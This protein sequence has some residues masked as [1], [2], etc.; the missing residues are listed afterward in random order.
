MPAKM[1][2]ADHNDDFL[3]AVKYPSNCEMNEKCFVLVSR[4]HICKFDPHN[5]SYHYT[6]ATATRLTAFLELMSWFSS[7]GER[8]GDG[9]R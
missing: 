7:K 9:S 1:G 2:S 4:G 8:R 3:P 6:T 5:E